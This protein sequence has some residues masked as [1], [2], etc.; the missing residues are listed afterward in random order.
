MSIKLENLSKKELIQLIRKRDFF[1]KET[2]IAAVR[3]DSLCEKASRK[4]EEAIAT[5]MDTAE[6]FVLHNKLW[7]DADK[8]NKEAD[9]IYSQYWPSR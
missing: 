3:W 1:L 6:G 2:D 8:I 7:N 4:R 9:R 5:K